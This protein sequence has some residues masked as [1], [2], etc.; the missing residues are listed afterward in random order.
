MG[1]IDKALRY[2]AMAGAVIADGIERRAA[3]T[4]A[5]EARTVVALLRGVLNIVIDARA[6]GDGVVHDLIHEI[7]RRA[8]HPNHRNDWTLR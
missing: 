5:P 7:E 8:G 4:I 6:T 1:P 3:R 2:L